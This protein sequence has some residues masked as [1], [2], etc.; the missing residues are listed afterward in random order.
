MNEINQISL[1]KHLSTEI[2]WGVEQGRQVRESL[3]RQVAARPACIVVVDMTGVRQADV[4]FSREA[5]VETL[6]RFR[7]A[8]QFIIANPENEV[9]V[10]NL[11]AALAK[12]GNAVVLKE[13][14]GTAKVIGNQ[15]SYA[16]RQILE[17]VQNLREATSRDVVNKISDLT[18]QNC[19]NKLRELWEE[20]LLYR[21]EMAARSGGREWKYVSLM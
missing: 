20:G 13:R 12:R 4:S 14:G 6:R 5:I 21:E 10:E 16:W 11:D 15:P 2:A 18:I 9:V 17:T 8:Y 1:R 3:E 19:S 7:P